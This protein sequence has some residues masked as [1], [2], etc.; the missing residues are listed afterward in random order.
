MD[1]MRNCRK[2]MHLAGRRRNISGIVAVDTIVVRQGFRNPDGHDCGHDILTA[3]ERSCNRFQLVTGSMTAGERRR[4]AV[5]VRVGVPLSPL[6]RRVHRHSRKMDTKMD[7]KTPD[8][9]VK[10]GVLCSIITHNV[11]PK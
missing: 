2:T 6:K 8:S 4:M 10:S 7:T 1:T 9:D 5:I 3:G 11:F